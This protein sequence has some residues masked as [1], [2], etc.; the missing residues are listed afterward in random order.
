MTKYSLDNKRYHTLNYFYKKKFGKKVFKVP[1]D[2][3]FS[4]PNKKYGG[5]I[6]CKDNSK[7]NITLNS[8]DL[9]K[10]F[11][12]A[13]TIMEKKWPNS[14]YIAYFQS[15]TNTYGPIAVL[16]KHIETVLKIPNVVGISIATR[17]DCLSQEYLNYFKAKNIFN[18]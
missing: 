18:H 15:G 4:C 13:K 11:E 3:G 17:P 1:L 8:N 2:L 10:Q 9:L 16:K 7:S 6:F 12:Y 14:Y 5:C